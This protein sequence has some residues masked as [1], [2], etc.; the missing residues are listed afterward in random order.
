MSCVTQG[1]RGNW[2]GGSPCVHQATRIILDTNRS[3]SSI[4]KM[5]IG[6]G[7][8]WISRWMPSQTSGKSNDARV[9]NVLFVG[10]LPPFFCT[11][12]W[13]DGQLL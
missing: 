6:G 11:A 7:I 5:A 8:M 3:C 13:V 9:G 10:L 1:L 4:D 12:G 2:V